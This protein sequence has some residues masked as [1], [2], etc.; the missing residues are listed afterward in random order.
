[1]K[2]AGAFSER[3]RAGE[4]HAR[5]A[6]QHNSGPTTQKRWWVVFGACFVAFVMGTSA[7]SLL[8]A[9]LNLAEIMLLID[10]TKRRKLFGFLVFSDWFFLF[11]CFLFLLV[12]FSNP[13]VLCPCV[14]HGEFP[15][16]TCENNA[17][18]MENA[19]EECHHFVSNTP[20][21]RSEPRNPFRL[22]AGSEAHVLGAF[23]W[24]NAFE[25]VLGVV[26]C[27]ATLASQAV[28]AEH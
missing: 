16:R 26:P 3:I 6:W 22:F 8:Q 23:W 12:P 11:F 19:T 13:F 10:T 25:L 5:K 18:S 20:G 27:F 4:H 17:T 2:D 7:C 21:T 24:R 15:N 9:S 14:C 28:L 1:M